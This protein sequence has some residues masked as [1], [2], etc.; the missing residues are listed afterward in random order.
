MNY[1]LI[2]G[3][4]KGIG[5]SIAEELA[6]RGCH[7]L[8]V[9][10]S[11]ALLKEGC[12]ALTSKYKIEARW[13]AMDL[14]KPGTAAAIF[15][16]CKTHQL[17]IDILVNNAGYGLSGPFE[18]YSEEEHLEMM[19][20]NM[21]TPVA[22]CRRFLPMLK[23]QPKAYILNIASMAAYQAVPGLT[24]YAASKAFVLSFSR[25]LKL[26]LRNTTVSVS[27]ISPG[28]TDTNFVNHAQVGAKGRKL[29]DKVNMTPEF[30]AKAAVTGMFAGK[31]E[32]IPGLINKVG[33]VITW[34]LPK[35]ILEKGAM[36]IYEP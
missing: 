33:M 16:Y 1:A 2:T 9:A 10:R 29:A 21:N 3:A 20:L 35:T 17:T 22:L 30:V 31:T 26:E 5:K 18:K 13:L 28:A 27:C 4:S 32:M 24:A 36:R 7:L 12:A 15:D 19:A 6:S 8:L 34:L 23:A 25:G 11:E 14:S